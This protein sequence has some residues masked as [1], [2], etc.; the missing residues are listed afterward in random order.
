MIKYIII[1]NIISFI[2]MGYDKYSAIKNKWR[3]KEKT[4]FSFAFIGGSLGILLGMIIFRHKTK[5][6]H[7]IY[8][9][10]LLLIINILSFIFIFPTIFK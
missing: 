1:I 6:R 9:I 2:I 3:I 7:F 4:L 8:L 5:K 10:P